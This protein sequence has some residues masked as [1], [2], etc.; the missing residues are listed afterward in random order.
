VKRRDLIVGTASGLVLANV[1]AL[2]QA[3]ERLP[4]VALLI[5]HPPVDAPIVGIWRSGMLKHG[6]IDGQ[7]VRLIV[8][9]AHGQLD[10]VPEIAQEL[11]D[12]PADV[13]VIVNE[14]ALN[15]VK[16]A[17]STTPIVMVG[18]TDDP[19]EEGWIDS[20]RRPGTNVTGIFNVNAN[21]VAKR[22]E[23]L[24]EVIPDI[25][26][27]AVFWD[28]V[29]GRRQLETLQSASKV[30]NLEIDVY[31]VANGK[32]LV[33][34]FKRAKRRKAGAVTLLWSPVFYVHRQEVAELALDAGLP[35]MADQ[36]YLVT[37]GCMVF[38]GAVAE[39]AFERAAYF[40]D[41]LLKGAT[42]DQL[43]VEQMSDVKLVVN[44]KTAKRLGIHVPQSILLRADEVIQ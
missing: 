23:V 44:L 11:V 27:V 1:P 6:Y 28:P 40:V 4:V 36:D 2:V 19:V 26:R 20:Y 16:Q 18:F 30:L 8:R 17:T 13:I 10:R 14:I 42:P 35:L 12:M 5:T 41:R 7:N 24:K 37:S 25:S 38:Y 32:D 31:Q 21:L 3:V 22:L 29:F 43:P 15:A 34:A 39:P 33:E 9:T